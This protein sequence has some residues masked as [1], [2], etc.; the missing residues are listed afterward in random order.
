MVRIYDREGQQQQE[1]NTKSQPPQC[2]LLTIV[3]EA[4]TWQLATI[5]YLVLLRSLGSLHPVIRSTSGYSS[6][7]GWSRL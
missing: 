3:A 6:S 5:H 4:G 2:Q 1:G 7:A